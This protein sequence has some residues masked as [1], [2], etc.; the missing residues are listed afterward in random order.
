MSVLFPYDRKISTLTKWLLKRHFDV[1]ELWSNV[2]DVILKTVIAAHPTLKHS[3][4]ACFPAHDFAYACFELLGF[5]ILLDY[6]LKPY[7][8]EVPFVVH[9]NTVFC[10]YIIRTIM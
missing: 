5:D 1:H 6:M 10:S 3:Y 4:H 2:D 9:S 7:V 8:L